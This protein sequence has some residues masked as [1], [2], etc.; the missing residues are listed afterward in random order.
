MGSTRAACV[1]A[2]ERFANVLNN[3][4]RAII[5]QW[6]QY[7]VD[8]DQRSPES[9]I[10][11]L[12]NRLL[13][14]QPR[15]EMYAG[16]PQSGG[17]K[18]FEGL[19]LSNEY[20]TEDMRKCLRSFKKYADCF[21]SRTITRD[22]LPLSDTNE[23]SFEMFVYN[24]ALGRSLDRKSWLQTL[25]S[26]LIKQNIRTSRTIFAIIKGVLDEIILLKCQ[27][28]EEFQLPSDLLRFISS[29][30]KEM[31]QNKSPGPKRKRSKSPLMIEK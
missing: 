12:I 31:T 6:L 25:T 18:L 22:D 7:W 16:G 5:E 3:G 20:L 30:F 10:R 28:I 17:I 2:T 21:F 26:L 11:L 9:D 27:T 1:T 14:E 13:L 29:E 8:N 24:D 19:S 15:F 4:R 23:Y